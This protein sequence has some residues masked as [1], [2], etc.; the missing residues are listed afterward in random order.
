MA[1]V[2]GNGPTARGQR[3]RGRVIGDAEPDRRGSAGQGV[4]QRDIGSLRDDQ[5]QPARPARIGEQRGAGAHDPDRRR[6]RRRLEQEHDALV[7]RPAFHVEQALDAAGRGRAT[8]A[9]P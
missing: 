4:G 2:V 3:A 6:L 9:I 7:E 1:E 8:T 5:G